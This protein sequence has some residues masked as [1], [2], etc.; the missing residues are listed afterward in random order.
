MTFGPMMKPNVW[1][2]GLNGIILRYDDSAWL[3]QASG[4]AGIINGIWG[5]SATNVRAMADDGNTSN[6]NLYSLI[7]Q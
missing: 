2:G 4:I 5:T 3:A 6:Y 7:A 1:A